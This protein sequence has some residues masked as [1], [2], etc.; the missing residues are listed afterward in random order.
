[1]F[2]FPRNRCWRRDKNL[3][4]RWKTHL[5]KECAQG[6]LPDLTSH[7]FLLL[8]S[9]GRRNFKW[10]LYL[11]SSGSGEQLWVL[12]WVKNV[13]H[14]KSFHIPRHGR[15]NW[16]LSQTCDVLWSWEM[17]F[18]LCCSCMKYS[19]WKFTSCAIWSAFLSKAH[20]SSTTL[21]YSNFLWWKSYFLHK[22]TQKERCNQLTFCLWAIHVW[23]LPLM[24][25]L[26]PHLAENMDSSSTAT[27]G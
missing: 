18:L 23:F 15:N 17:V 21:K 24:L 27:W 22:K 26:F 11:Y 10:C 6:S 14:C 13:P 3:H 7:L 9:S 4:S 5:V 19:L 1:M 25:R 2:R 8:S 16:G 12:M 20:F